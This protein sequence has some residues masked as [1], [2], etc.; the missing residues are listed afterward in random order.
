MAEDLK[1]VVEALAN[2]DFLK[3]RLV[4]VGILFD[5]VHQLRDP[6]RAVV[7]LAHQ[8]INHQDPNDPHQ[9]RAEYGVTSLR[10]QR[11]QPGDFNAPLRQ[12]RGNLPR[13]RHASRIEPFSEAIFAIAKIERIGRDRGQVLPGLAFESRNGFSLLISQGMLQ[14]PEA[15]VAHRLKRLEQTA[16]GAARC[17]GRIIQFMGEAGGEL[18]QRH[19]L[20]MLRLQPRGLADAI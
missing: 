18:A 17:G 4:H 7:D 5:G 2:I 15:R 13:L 20:I 10:G 11:L 12:H 1:C 3:R 14:K 16:G 19:Q 9:R 8:P 6:A